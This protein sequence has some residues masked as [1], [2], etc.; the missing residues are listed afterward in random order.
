MPDLEIPG[1]KFDRSA[2]LDRDVA[3][4][5]FNGGLRRD[6]RGAVAVESSARAAEARQLLDGEPDDVVEYR[7][8]NGW[9]DFV[10]ASELEQRTQTDRGAAPGEA[11]DLLRALGSET[12]AAATRDAGQRHRRSAALRLGIPC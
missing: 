8:A 2:D 4:L 5:S 9:V 11:I 12:G 6:V 10:R 7:D 1:R 3:E